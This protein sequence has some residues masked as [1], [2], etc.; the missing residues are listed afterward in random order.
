MYFS[1]DR[2]VTVKTIEGAFYEE[3]HLYI[4]FFFL[5]FFLFILFA[6]YDVPV[7]EFELFFTLFFIQFFSLSFFGRR[8]GVYLKNRDVKLGAII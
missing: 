6:F 1:I 3:K 4:Y 8:G 5:Q 2:N 7:F